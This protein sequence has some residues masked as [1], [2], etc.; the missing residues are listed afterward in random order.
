MKMR[1][2]VL[3]IIPVMIVSAFM[4]FILQAESLRDWKG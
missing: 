4:W 3:L 2:A 1:Y